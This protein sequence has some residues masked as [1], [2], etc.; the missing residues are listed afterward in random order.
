M[1]H[2]NINKIQ[3]AF[4]I[5]KELI[6]EHCSFSENSILQNTVIKQRHHSKQSR[7]CSIVLFSKQ[8]FNLWNF[9]YAIGFQW[10][11]ERCA[12]KLNSTNWRAAGAIRWKRDDKTELMAFYQISDLSFVWKIL[13]H[14]LTSIR[15]LIKTTRF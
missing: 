2:A 5:N 3:I 15:S 4:F 10:S 11:I 1:G 12:V 8:F 13:K 9:F 14:I 7:W 6:L